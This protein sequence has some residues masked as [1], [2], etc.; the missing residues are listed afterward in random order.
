[1]WQLFLEYSVKSGTITRLIFPQEKVIYPHLSSPHINPSHLS[2]SFTH[3]FTHS[4]ML[5][6]HIIIRDLI[7]Y[8]LLVVFTYRN[9]A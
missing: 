5:I 4:F 8:Y 1:M 2:T 9:R 6:S 7:H 3:S